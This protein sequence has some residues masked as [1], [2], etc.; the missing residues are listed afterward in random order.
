M[1]GRRVD[2]APNPGVRPLQEGV[3]ERP[4]GSRQH[5]RHR[6]EDQPGWSHHFAPEEGLA[7]ERRDQVV[8][9]EVELPDHTDVVAALG[10]ERD[11]GL[12][13][14]LEELAG[15]E[16]PGVDGPRGFPRRG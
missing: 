2:R 6:E 14:E 11:H 7:E 10:V 5:Q 16:E 9:I 12:E 4:G 3:G 13:A 8:Q 15:P 1:G